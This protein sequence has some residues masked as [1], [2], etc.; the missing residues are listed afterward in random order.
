[1]LGEYD[2]SLGTRKQVATIR[3]FRRL[4][5]MRPPGVANKHTVQLNETR[6]TESKTR[7]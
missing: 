7:L 6:N 5:M 3:G 1:M 4:R 2:E